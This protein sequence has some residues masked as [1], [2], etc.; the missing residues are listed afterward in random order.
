MDTL[1]LALLLPWAL[2]LMLFSALWAAEW[3]LARHHQARVRRRLQQVR[4][5]LPS[6]AQRNGHSPYYGLTYPN[7]PKPYQK[8]VR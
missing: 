1:T 2:G 4:G 7:I 5:L 6:E 8:K 3:F